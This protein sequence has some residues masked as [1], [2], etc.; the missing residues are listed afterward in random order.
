MKP[1]RVMIVIALVAGAAIGTV[2]SHTARAGTNGQQLTVRSVAAYRVYV[3]G[4]NQENEHVCH[5]WDT[6][7]SVTPLN[8]WWWVGCTTVQMYGASRNLVAR[9]SVNVPTFQASSDYTAVYETSHE[10]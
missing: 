4:N 8:G 10:C 7:K 9:A 6:P 5:S 1:L 3:C 2:G